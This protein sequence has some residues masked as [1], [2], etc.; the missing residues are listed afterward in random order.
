MDTANDFV[1]VGVLAHV[2][3]SE[4]FFPPGIYLDAYF[5]G[6]GFPSS[7]AEEDSMNLL[8]PPL[9]TSSIIKTTI[10]STGNSVILFPPAPQESGWII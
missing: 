2:S 5:V 9:N 3:G 4:I 7:K 10:V 1:S 8:L 6:I